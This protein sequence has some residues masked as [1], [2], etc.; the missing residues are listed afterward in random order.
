MSRLPNASTNSHF[1]LRHAS[2]RQ[3]QIFDAVSRHLSF[4]R[5]AQELFLTQPTVSA[6][7][8]SFAEAIDMP[9]YEQV[10]RNIYL[11]EVGEKVANS[12]RDIIDRL[13]NL[14]IMLDDYKGL[15]RGR[16]RVAIV[17]TAKY[18]TPKALG[19][20]CKKHTDI[21]LSLK[22]TNRENLFKRIEQNLDDL[23]IIGQVPKNSS[24]LEVVPY[25]PNPLVIIAHPEHELVGQKVTLKRLA[26]EP[27][28]MREEGSGI[29]SAL[30]SLFSAQGLKINERLTM[31]TYESIKHCVMADLGVACVSMH[32]LSPNEHLNG[33]VAV[34]D[35]EGFP[36]QK[37]WNIVY[38][39]GKELSVL[40]HEFLEFLQENRKDY[41]Q[42]IN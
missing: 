3:I 18:F 1:L 26:N 30:E 34:L 41:V 5:A 27:F 2:L 14:E 25:I 22:V 40:A 17:T 21:E 12:C 7:V 36:L 4:T 24:E 23:Y 31:E 9:L 15:K 38:P 13:S 32:A 6:Q 33:S 42:S 10:G 28:I 39:K 16:L 8:K 35:V 20:F 37:Q 11:T 29:R 19:E